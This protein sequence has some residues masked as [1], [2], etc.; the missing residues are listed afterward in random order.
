[1]NARARLAAAV[2]AVVMSFGLGPAVGWCDEGVQHDPHLHHHVPKG[3][4]R[5]AASYHVPDVVLVDQHHEEVSL[6]G[7][8]EGDEPLMLN[9]I[10]ATCTTVCPVMAAGFSSIQQQL[11]D[12]AQRMR[13]VSITIDPEHDNPLVL[14]AYARRFQGGP[15][16]TGPS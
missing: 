13:L 9:F 15:G 8:L 10:F 12:G 6:T 14:S 4:V 3:I 7:L 5:S 16:W 2:A 1:M 11:G